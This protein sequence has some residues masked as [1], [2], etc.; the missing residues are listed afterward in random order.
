[1]FAESE[2]SILI[3]YRLILFL[4]PYFYNTFITM[5]SYGAENVIV[6]DL[7]ISALCY[8]IFLIKEL[9]CLM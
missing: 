9:S 7:K 2:G 6:L 3:N 5:L 4:D 8:A 1:M